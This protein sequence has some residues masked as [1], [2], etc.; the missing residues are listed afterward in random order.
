MPIHF[1][2]PP[3]QSPEESP[4]MEEDQGGDAVGPKIRIPGFP[5]RTLS[6]HFE[7]PPVLLIFIA[8]STTLD[9]GGFSQSLR[10]IEADDLNYTVRTVGES[11][12]ASA[13]TANSR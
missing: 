10:G 8:V 7:E 5:D 4:D 3:E 6:P 12:T 2:L 11:G 1:L 13:G 9:V